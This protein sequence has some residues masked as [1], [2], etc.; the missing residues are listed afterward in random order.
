MQTYINTLCYNAAWDFHVTEG[1]EG[2]EY[3]TVLT[4]KYNGTILAFNAV[5]KLHFGYAYRK[6]FTWRYKEK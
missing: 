2:G 4:F 3:R 6:E 5:Q 1:L